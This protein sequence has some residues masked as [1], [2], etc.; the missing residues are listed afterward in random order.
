MFNESYKT[1]YSTP[2]NPQNPKD[3]ILITVE[4]KNLSTLEKKRT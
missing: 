1:S 3:K 4:N 2:T